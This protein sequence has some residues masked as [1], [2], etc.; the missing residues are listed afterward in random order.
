MDGAVEGTSQE[1]PGPDV[2]A[3]ALSRSK[4]HGKNYSKNAFEGVTRKLLRA[5]QSETDSDEML[6]VFNLCVRL[7]QKT[8]KY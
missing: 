2:S 6:G 7:Q 8:S 1:A 4:D 3:R 5:S